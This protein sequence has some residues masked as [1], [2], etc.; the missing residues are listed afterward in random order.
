VSGKP[1]AA[2]FSSR[3]M[4]PEFDPV[5]IQV[6]ESRDS[7]DNPR[8]RPVILAADVT[9]SMGMIANQLVTGGGLNDLATEIQTKKPFPDPHVMVMAVGDAHFDRAPLQVT[10]FE[11]DIRIAQQTQDLWIEKGGGTNTGE[12]YALAHLFAA[13][14]TVSD[15]WEKRREKGFLFTI[16]DEP[17]IGVTR[18]QAS[19]FLGVD[20][21]RDLSPA[22]CAALAMETWEV[23]HVVLVNEGYA[24]SGLK[25][26]LRTWEAALPQR[27]I[28]LDDVA[29]LAEAVVAA[30]QIAEGASKAKVASGWSGDTAVAVAN[31]VS[32]LAERSRGS[33]GAVRLA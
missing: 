3:S 2:V 6:R 33:S 5:N 30:I 21:P 4:K 24:A 20:I 10:Q 17:T 14:K 15:A 16:G 27:L 23:Y 11:A 18:A 28:L 12:S 19:R 8:S 7:A 26:V 13:R 31:A 32:C 1:A 29:K 22:E 9:G 25:E